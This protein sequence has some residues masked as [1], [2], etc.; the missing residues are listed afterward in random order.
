MIQKIYL[1]LLVIF[2]TCAAGESAA[3]EKLYL[4]LNDRRYHIGD[5]LWY[6]GY[7]MHEPTPWEGK[8]AS[9]VVYVELRN[10]EGI[11]IGRNRHAI[12]QSRFEGHL[13]LQRMTE[14][15]YYEVRAYTADMLNY[16]DSI[17]ENG[18]AQWWLSKEINLGS[19]S[20]DE[21]IIPPIG[22][23]SRGSD[24]TTASKIT[25]KM[26]RTSRGGIVEFK[27]YNR[28]KYE[29]KDHIAGGNE[30]DVSGSFASPNRFDVKDKADPAAQHSFLYVRNPWIYSRVFP[31]Y[32][33]L[34]KEPL[35]A[36]YSPSM[37]LR[38]G[39]NRK[40]LP[41]RE[42]R[43]E[44]KF[45]PE[46][47]QLVEGTLTRI[48]FEI[49]N[50]DGSHGAPQRLWLQHQDGTCDT[51]RQTLHRGKGFIVTDSVFWTH[52]TKHT[53]LYLRNGDE[54]RH[55]RL[56]EAHETGVGLYCDVLTDTVIALIQPVGIS[57]ERLHHVIV[58]E[59]N[60]GMRTGINELVV[61]DDAGQ[62]LASRLFFIN[63]HE[64]E[65]HLTTDIA[66]DGTQMHPCQAVGIPLC[67]TDA[68]GLPVAG[69]RL[70]VAVC[71]DIDKGTEYS[72]GNL[73]T[74]M[75]L[76]SEVRGFIENPEYYFESD[77]SLHRGHLDLLLLVQGWRRYDW[78]LVSG[79]RTAKGFYPVERQL[80]VR[81]QVLP[82]LEKRAHDGMLL[83]LEIHYSDQFVYEAVDTLRDNGR[84][85]F[86]VPQVYGKYPMSL[87]PYRNRKDFEADKPDF[88]YGRSFRW[89][90]WKQ[91]A[92]GPMPEVYDYYQCHDIAP[93]R[94]DSD[95]L[96]TLVLDVVSVF[97][98]PKVELRLDK[99]L[100]RYP[101]MEWL[102]FVNDA[103]FP[104]FFLDNADDNV[105][106]QFMPEVSWRMF[107]RTHNIRSDF[108]YRKFSITEVEQ[109]SRTSW[110][111]NAT[112]LFVDSLV[113][114][115]YDRQESFYNWERPRDNYP[116]RFSEISF[117]CD[118]YDR[119]RYLDDGK[120]HA[121]TDLHTM[122]VTDSLHYNI[123]HSPDAEWMQF[124]GFQQP[125][126]FY[127][128]D[129]SRQPL[130]N[131][132]HP[133][134]RHALYWNPCLVTDADGR[135]TVRFYNNSTAQGY[136]LDMNGLTP[137]GRICTLHYESK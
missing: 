91:R 77:D 62:K 22:S 95:S 134:R 131:K 67:V 94:S 69:A 64:R 21:L 37:T 65:A 76:G 14:A 66:R 20:I 61:Y 12:S 31:V 124:Y 50:A 97:Q 23:V 35:P 19:V 100:V 52:Y 136:T 90:I 49:R 103:L 30:A 120:K 88:T 80:M 57:S 71:D 27:R 24:V 9:T 92:L 8:D 129:Y 75:L 41:Q 2:S 25:K 10:Q 79:R 36:N 11:L 60:I 114:D 72:A 115:E 29:L 48:A 123:F 85:A 86:H 38:P 53:R 130:L 98:N 33:P 3:T 43:M 81:G 89:R 137:D 47:G 28:D 133:D 84:F 99:P 112:K 4:H 125:A 16:H 58:A 18:S 45:Y 63:R 32:D 105:N 106:N 54:T 110:I 96:P 107:M 128:P 135:A 122:V 42:H 121:V 70:S 55:Y 7:Y 127:Q 109:P 93:T 59:G 44:V 68:A 51:L 5:T 6:A 108:G 46:G 118:L 117:Y 111:H 73:L 102:D 26:S 126:E 56:P 39:M 17:P 1:F 119:S 34:P 104:R 40:K 116:M 13:S 78:I 83:K 87:T 113:W 15:G 132:E 74:E 101:L 82:T